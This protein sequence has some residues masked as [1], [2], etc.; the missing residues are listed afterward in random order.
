MEC[1]IHHYAENETASDCIAFWTD[2]APEEVCGYEHLTSLAAERD[3][4]YSGRKRLEKLNR[5]R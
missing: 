1:F 5:A 3:L 4:L 2:L